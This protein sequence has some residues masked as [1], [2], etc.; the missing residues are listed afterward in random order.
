M[1]AKDC[2]RAGAAGIDNLAGM[3]TRAERVARRHWRISGQKSGPSPGEAA[4]L[5]I[6]NRAPPVRT[7]SQRHEG[8]HRT[9]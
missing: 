3:S 7:A 8:Y 5:V 9:S 6:C 4:V 2:S 1:G